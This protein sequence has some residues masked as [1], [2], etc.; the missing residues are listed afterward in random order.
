MHT[1]RVSAVIVIYNFYF[2][3]HEPLNQT[4][5]VRLFSEYTPNYIEYPNNNSNMYTTQN[6]YLLYIPTCRNEQRIICYQYM[7]WWN[8]MKPTKN[9]IDHLSF[10]YYSRATERLQHTNKYLKIRDNTIFFSFIHPTFVH[11]IS[12]CPVDK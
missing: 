10:N 4:S 11:Q 2:F 1:I 3:Y 7:F 6:R 5:V 12:H 9:K 8:M